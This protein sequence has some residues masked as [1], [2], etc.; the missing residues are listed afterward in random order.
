MLRLA[1]FCCVV[2][3][4]DGKPAGPDA[5][6]DDLDGDGIANVVD[7]CARADNPDQHDEDGDGLGDVCDNC[8]T[9]ANPTQADTTE[10]AVNSFEDGVGDACDYRPGF[11]GDQVGAFFSWATAEQMNAW[12]GTGWTID[13]DELRTIGAARWQIKRGEAGNGLIVVARITALDLSGGALTI[14]LDGDGIDAGLT[15]TLQQGGA[16]LV[17]R[18]LGGATSVASIAVLDPIAPRTLVA[19]RR[20]TTVTN[21][22]ECR[23]EQG[24]SHAEASIVLIDDTFIGSYV[25]AS[26]GA[27]AS[28]SSVIV[29][30]SPGPKNP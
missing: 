3:A 27:I 12:T 10:V 17:A 16:E 21:E 4:C 29:L 14:A 20:V 19:W 18:E 26:S 30:T 22:L 8:P 6:P 9:T 11:A 15:C 13:S 24:S 7:N 28:L 1:G 25:L 23:I 5:D 2:F